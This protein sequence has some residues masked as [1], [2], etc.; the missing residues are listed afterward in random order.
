METPELKYKVLVATDPCYPLSNTGFGIV[1]GKLMRG[2]VDSQRFV[3]SHLARGYVGDDLT[4]WPECRVWIPPAWDRNGYQWI[5]NAI[6]EEKPELIVIEADPGSIME[7]RRN[8]EVRAIPNL[9]H[10]PV[11][12]EPLLSPWAEAM[13]EI[14]LEGGRI[15]CY[16]EYSKRVIDAATAPVLQAFG[17][18]IAESGMSARRFPETEV[19]RLGVDH[20]DFRPD[21]ELRAATRTRLGWRDNFVVLNVARNAGRKNWPRLFEAVKLV[22]ETHPEVLL[23]AHTIPFENYFLGGHDL[24]TLRRHLGMEDHIIFKRDMQDAYRG[25]PFDQ[26]QLASGRGDLTLAAIYNAADLFC[27]P[28]GGEGHNLPQ[29]EAAASGVPVAT[30]RYAGG[31]EVA[32]SFAMPLVPADY[33]TDCNGM[34]F[35]AVRAADIAEVII[36][37][38]EHPQQAHACVQAGLAATAQMRWQ[39]TVERFVEIAV[40]MC[41]SR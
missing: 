29:C 33:H 20:A 26:S 14:M 41:A 27:A 13:A 31:W 3:V 25:V 6:K 17:K 38:L 32:Q 15:T 7:W 9:V 12:A 19:L 28:T 8:P 35:A 36:Y 21:P 5:I 24:F 22:V 16:T 30:T 37:A 40:E 10:T 11:E 23:Y 34:R 2:L 1:G 18:D 39:P 4:A